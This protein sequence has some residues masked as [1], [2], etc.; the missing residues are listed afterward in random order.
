MTVVVIRDERIWFFDAVR[1]QG[2]VDNAQ[3]PRRRGRGCRN[4][5]AEES[6]RLPAAP[7][8]ETRHMVLVPPVLDALAALVVL[9]TGRRVAA[10]LT[11]APAA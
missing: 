4:S 1:V 11:T 6:Q 8:L 5:S 10:D 9:L 3:A 2:G 7:L